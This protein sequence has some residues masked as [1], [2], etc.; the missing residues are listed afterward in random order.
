MVWF[1]T[2]APNQT[3]KM[4]SCEG[5][6]EFLL[7]R[8]EQREYDEL[9]KCK[10]CDIL[11]F[12]DDP[13]ITSIRKSGEKSGRERLKLLQETLDG[14]EVER[15]DN[16]KLFHREMTKA[17]IPLLF[18]H[19]LDANIDSLRRELDTDELQLVKNVEIAPK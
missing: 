11:A 6:F 3:K 16:Q 4:N 13:F 12:L 15:S 7:Q 5:D 18:K 9:Q 17:A 14:F 19:D 2:E 8:Y 1:G 10:P